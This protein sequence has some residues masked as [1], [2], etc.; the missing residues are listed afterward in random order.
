MG[1]AREALVVVVL[2]ALCCLP[3]PR[4]IFQHAGGGG[5]FL[6]FPRL[7]PMLALPVFLYAVLNSEFPFRRRILAHRLEAGTFAGAFIV[8]VLAGSLQA[9]RHQAGMFDH[10]RRRFATPAGVLL[11]GEPAVA[12]RD[13][14]LTQM[15]GGSPDFATVRQRGIWTESVFGAEDEFH[16]SATCLSPDLWSEAA[17]QDSRVVRVAPSSNLFETKVEA[18]HAEV[19]TVSRDGEW[20]AFIRENH[21]RG[22]LWIKPLA[23][24]A[25]LNP[26]DERKVSSDQIDVWEAAFAP[27]DQEIVFTAAPRGEAELFSL[28]RSSMRITPL[29]LPTPA[30]YPAVS[31]DGE[32]LAF[33]HFEHGEWRLELW[34][35][36]TQE[37]R[38]IAEGDCNSISPVWSADGKELIYA[39]DCGRGLE[40]TA[41]E[42]IAVFP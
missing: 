27:G 23:K 8:L 33:S 19:P 14:Y 25:R 28:D 13:L 12:A 5:M 41:L 9:L 7:Y 1:R 20:L 26:A 30:R 35:P 3:W 40:M 34:S 10:Y 18:L 31:P 32:W 36:R 37:I 17:D 21:G 38:H 22:E 4:E 16:P 29:P 39:S 15:P 2:Y 24:V 42:H 6:A 11:A